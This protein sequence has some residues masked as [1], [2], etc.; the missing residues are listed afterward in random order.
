MKKNLFYLLNI[1]F[2]VALLY[3]CGKPVDLSQYRKYK[4]PENV[5]SL[6]ISARDPIIQKNDILDIKI[7]LVG[8]QTA[9]ELQQFYSPNGSA[10][11]QLQQQ[12]AVGILVDPFDGTITIPSIGD[13]PAAGKTKN[14]L[15]NLIYVKLKA[16][17]KVPVVT[18]RIINFSVYIE[19]EVNKPGLISVP[20]EL[21]TL[22]QA[23]S[24]AGGNTL[25]AV[26]SDVQVI[27]SDNVGQK[28]VH[29][30][31]LNDELYTTK[32]EFFYLRQGDQ[33]NLPANKE[34]IVSSNQSTART[35][36]YAS[37]AISIIIGLFAIFAR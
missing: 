19:G 36:G 32:K 13:I 29:I 10:P 6:T 3:S 11:N 4:T 33:I 27:R 5:D 14:E 24:L 22:Q 37:T 34:K 9:Q 7:S 12:G 18:I 35:I 30:N 25:F 31:L 17:V 16:F 8:G 23:I 15:K 1:V 2:T 26:L 20:N 28:L 21:I